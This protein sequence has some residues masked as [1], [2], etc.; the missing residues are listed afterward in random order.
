MGI[1]IIPIFGYNAVVIRSFGNKDTEKIYNQ[2]FVRS[3]HKDVQTQ[4]L[5]R[6]RYIDAATILTDLRVPPSN[7]LH[8]LK[9]D[10]EGFHAIRVNK[11]W[12]VIFTFSEGGA[13]EV[14]I[15]DYH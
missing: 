1:C 8:D 5:R 2:E 3:L 9:G 14:E 11:Q 15:V 13:D 12:R 4:A 10:L 6:L 7:N